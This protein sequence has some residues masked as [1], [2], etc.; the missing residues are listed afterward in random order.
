[1]TPAKKRRAVQQLARAPSAMGIVARE[2]YA[3]AR[4]H[5]L[6][7][8]ELAERSRLSI[9]MLE[10]PGTRLPALGQ[11]RFLNLVAGACDDDALGQHLATTFDARRS[12]LY[13][14]VLASAPSLRVL[15]ERSARF[16][17]LVN[18]GLSQEF[19]EGRQVGLVMKYRGVRRQLDRHQFEF[20]LVL[21]VKVCRELTGVKLQPSRVQVAHSPGRQYS[22]LSRFLGCPVEF[23][24]GVDEILFTR[25]QAALPLRRA[26]PYLHELLL[27]VCEQELSRRKRALNSFVTRVENAVA[28]RLPHGRVRAAEVAAEFGLSERTF[29]RRLAAEGGTFSSLVDR[30]RRDL[31]R[32]YLQEGAMPVSRVAWLLGYCETSAFTHAFRRWTG[33]VPSEVARRRE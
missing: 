26:D 21:L 12:G 24:A 7:V 17:T 29:A 8:R 32:Q 9:K 19:V 16:T 6:P 13:Y 15:L 27:G 11:I 18:E 25:E 10:N 33:K 20:W 1:M 22:K 4:A 30:L 31:A 23:G 28:P 14:Y 2:A 5:G 3:H